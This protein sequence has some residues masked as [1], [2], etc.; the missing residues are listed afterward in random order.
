M[1]EYYK[2]LIISLCEAGETQETIIKMLPFERNTSMYIIKDLKKNG[3]IKF[4]R[5][6]S[7]ERTKQIILSYY[8]NGVTNPYQIAEET[9]YSF[10]TINKLLCE[11]KLGRKRPTKNYKRKKLC[12]KTEEIVECLKMGQKSKEI[13]EKYKVSKQYV[14]Q[15][16]KQ[17]LGV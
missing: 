12:R 16:K 11:M 4:G 5:K 17:Y 15:L 3:I 1:N 2:Q 10:N 6:T 8:M 14:S 9:G 13:Q 7:I